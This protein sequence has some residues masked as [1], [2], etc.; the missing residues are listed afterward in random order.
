MD[1]WIGIDHLQWKQREASLDWE[2]ERD[3]ES[4]PSYYFIYL[5]NFS[6]AAAEAVFLLGM[7]GVEKTRARVLR[8]F[9][10][11]WQKSRGFSRKKRK[12]FSVAFF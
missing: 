8:C 11:R 4:D 6:L 9:I 5:F 1:G 3:R 7:T 10:Y 2:R 12:C